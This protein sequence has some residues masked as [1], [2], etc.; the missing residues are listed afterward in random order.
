MRN[1]CIL[2]SMICALLFSGGCAVRAPTELFSLP[3][4]SE[5]YIQLQDLLSEQVAAGNEYAAPTSGNNRQSIQRSDLDGDGVTEALSFFRTPEQTPEICIYRSIDEKYHLALTLQGVGSSINRVE[6][7]EL[8]NHPGNEL[9]VSWQINNDTRLL[10]VYSLE[11]FSGA[12]LLEAN[13][14]D[15]TLADLDGDGLQ[16][17]LALQYSKKGDSATVHYYSLEENGELTDNSAPLSQELASP[18]KMRTG[19]L[20]D[21]ATALFVEG[22]GM[23]GISSVTDIFTWTDGKFRNITYRAAADGLTTRPCQVYAEDVDGDQRLEVPAAHVLPRPDGSDSAYFVF[24]WYNYS[25]DGS[26]R[27]SCSSYHCTADGWYLLL[28]EALRKNLT[29]RREESVSEERVMVLSTL[30]SDGT[31]R[32]ALTIYTITGENRNER[33]KLPGRF[34]LL[35]TDTTIYAAALPENSELQQETVQ[36]GF[37]LIYNEW[38]TGVNNA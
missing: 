7:A 18:T 38:N 29:V 19:T 17:L 21:G 25:S 36:N 15:F 16:E 31:A 8:D 34:L 11:N 5:E 13:A 26:R 23:D 27:L 30:Q 1:K 12:T 20:E 22:S 9:I 37:H 6:Y 33:S 14:Q 28:P 35:E 10:R 4:P 3:Q 24:D 32:D 2:L